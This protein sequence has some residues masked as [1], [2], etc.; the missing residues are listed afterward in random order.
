MDKVVLK[1]FKST[2]EEEKTAEEEA[3]AVPE[4]EMV[5]RWSLKIWFKLSYTNQ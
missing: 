5:M 1:N 4:D 3:E 2:T